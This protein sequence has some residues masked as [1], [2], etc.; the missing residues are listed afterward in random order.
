MKFSCPD[1]LLFDPEARWPEYPCGEAASV[2]CGLNP[3]IPPQPTSPAPIFPPRPV[4]YP[5]RP[6]VAPRPIPP[7]PN[8]PRPYPKPIPTL[9]PEPITPE[10]IDPWTYTCS[11]E[12]KFY[13]L[14]NDCNGYIECKVNIIY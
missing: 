13:S 4:P 5:P 2:R 9:A 1:G 6:T 14:P 12:N 8:P 10:P 7:R 11:E 3:D